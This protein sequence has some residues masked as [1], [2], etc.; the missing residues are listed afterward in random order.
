MLFKYLCVHVCIVYVFVYIIEVIKCTKALIFFNFMYNVF[1]CLLLINY[2]YML[3]IYSIYH[4][5]NCIFFFFL[6][7]ITI[8][9]CLNCTYYMYDPFTC[10]V[11]YINSV[12]TYCNLH[13]Y[14]LL[15]SSSVSVVR[16]V[17]TYTVFTYTMYVF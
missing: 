15:Q 8:L 1:T 9:R 10:I 5:F 12:L 13:V 2:H 7:V 17:F 14:I 4:L 3:F 16:N 11:M 6:C